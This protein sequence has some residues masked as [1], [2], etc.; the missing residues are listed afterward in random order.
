MSEDV[1]TNGAAAIHLIIL[2]L[3]VVASIVAGI[4]V[5]RDAK[6]RDYNP[7]VW[8]LLFPLIG[9]L[10]LRNPIQVA[11]ILVVGIPAYLLLR[12]KGEIKACPHCSGKYIDELA[13]C[14]HCKKEVKKECLKC[15]DLADLDEARCPHCG[16][17]MLMYE[18][19]ESRH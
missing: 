8:G 1:V 10:S 19:R 13:F 3:S 6:V 12:P 9:L 18:G 16:A 17:P 5:Y 2:A 11:I 7:F 15:H 4:L 14:P